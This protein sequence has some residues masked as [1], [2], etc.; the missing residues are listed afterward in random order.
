MALNTESVN[1]L[2]LALTLMTAACGIVWYGIAGLRSGVIPDTRTDTFHRFHHYRGEFTFWF[3][4][5][6]HLFAGAGLAGL[7]V[8]L[9]ATVLF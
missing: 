3:I 5:V 8:W 4:F 6:F 7:S 1:V 2:I 9:V